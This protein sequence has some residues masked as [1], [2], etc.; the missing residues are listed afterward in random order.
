[1]LET[2]KRTTVTNMPSTIPCLTNC[3]E[4]KKARGVYIYIYI[5]QNKLVVLTREM[6]VMRGFFRYWRLSA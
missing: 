2:I 6:V 4:T 1:M 5:L 3:L